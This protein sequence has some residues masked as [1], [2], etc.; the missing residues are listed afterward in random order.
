MLY[1]EL[2]SEIEKLQVANTPF[3]VATIVDGQGSI[4]QVIGAKAIFTTDGLHTGTV[5]GG[6]LEIKCRDKAS[7]LLTAI[8][9]EPNFFARWNI[10]KDVNMTCGGEVAMYFEV[11]RPESEWNIVVFGAGHVSQKLCRFLT[12][13]ECR[14]LCIDT[15]Q[16]WLD[17]LPQSERLEAHQVDHFEDGVERINPSDT[18]ILMTM[19]HS[20]DVPVL[21]KIHQSAMTLPFVGM[22]GSDSK[23]R[24]VR[25]ELQEDKLP[26]AFIDSIICPIG[27]PE[28]GDNTPPEIAVSV[29]SQLLKMRQ[30]SSAKQPEKV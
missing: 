2:Q 24:I 21:K 22:I 17:K 30:S 6:K 28:V 23:A 1:A 4:P 10:Q 12:E 5:G 16:E 27:D 20:S 9:T 11:F 18:V 13:L 25:K 26:D 7:E 15:R 29:V 19:G 8:E 3:C 14:V